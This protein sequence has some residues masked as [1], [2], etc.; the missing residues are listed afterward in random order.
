MNL[1]FSNSAKRLAWCW[2]AIA[3]LV[4]GVISCHA[5][6]IGFYLDSTSYTAVQGGSI[7]G[8]V[9]ITAVADLYDNDYDG[10]GD[11]YYGYLT[12]WFVHNG[13]DGYDA[14]TSVVING[15]GSHPI[16]NSSTQEVDFA[17]GNY[18]TVGFT[19]S[20][21]ANSTAGYDLTGTVSVDSYDPYDD[22]YDSIIDGN[23]YY[24][25]CEYVYCDSD[26][27]SPTASTVTVLNPNTIMDINVTGSSQLTEGEDSQ[28]T[29]FQISRADNYNTRT[30]YFTI[31]GSAE[32]GVDYTASFS[33]TT[34]SVTI[35]A[36]SYSANID[37]STFPDA[38]L[39]DL[40]EPTALTLTVIQD[41]LQSYQI[42]S[43]NSATITFQND[44]TENGDAQLTRSTSLPLNDENIGRSKN[45][46]VPVSRWA[47]NGMISSS[48]AILN[49]WAT[50]P[51]A[52]SD[53]P[54]PGEFTITRG[55]SLSNAFNLSFTVTGTASAGT[56]YTA[57]PSSIAFAAN[58]T[59][60]NLLVNVLTNTILT[61]AQ[62]V[63]FTLNASNQYF[64]GYSTQ[65]VV[66]ILPTGAPTNSVASPVSRYWRGTGSDPTY[67]SQV[68]PLDAETGTVYSNL[69]GNCTS[70]YAGLP[71]WSS[72]PLYHFNATNTLSQTNTANRIAFNNP[73]VAF[74]ERVGGTPLYFSQPYDFGVY[75]GNPL[76][77]TNQIVIQ[78]YNR[79]SL[80]ITTIAAVTTNF[81][82]NVSTMPQS[83]WVGVAYGNGTFVAIS[84]DGDNNAACS[85]NGINWTTTPM[86]FGNLYSS[87]YA[88]GVNGTNGVFAAVSIGSSE[89]AYSPNG[90][91]WTASP[92]VGR[93]SLMAAIDLWWLIMVRPRPLTAPT[94]SI[95]R[96][97]PCPFPITGSR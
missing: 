57:L 49:V 48:S 20:F 17:A 62:T 35:A 97:P 46:N 23:P 69:N 75:A 94:A 11:T 56:N 71:S 6:G 2:L 45:G 9:G 84:G 28:T 91:N 54:T 21:P 7:S 18:A 15:S 25:Y 83:D 61:N 60:T 50:G 96:L 78:A 74:G 77:A 22:P 87:A 59:S 10:Y 38:D 44:D 66:T 58:Q 12:D 34:G 85:T 82:W 88:T 19:M 68:I 5:Q 31:G 79:N 63:V 51:F 92:S 4:A 72:Q 47:T 73:L 24:Y 30:V 41:P 90:I 55:G 37:V 52:T 89:S 32:N 13:N 16:P 86:P 67:W 81:I 95:G 43:A 33:G 40:D 29:T 42:G 64:L 27:Y 26:F 36:G 93:P 76:L 39:F 1:F 70:L 80:G 65:A 8:N 3:L 14:P 53:G